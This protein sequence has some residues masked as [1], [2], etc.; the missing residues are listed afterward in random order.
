MPPQRVWSCLF[1]G[2]LISSNILRVF[3]NGARLC[4]SKI[5]HDT[6]G[7]VYNV[8]IGIHGKDGLSTAMS[9]MYVDDPDSVLFEVLAMR[10]QADNKGGAR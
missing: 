8:A 10:G 6:D 3:Y 7:F 2:F 5:H 4:H 1:T 9:L